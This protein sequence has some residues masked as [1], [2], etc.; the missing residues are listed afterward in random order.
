MLSK[1]KTEGLTT[2][3]R[4]SGI[5]SPQSVEAN[6]VLETTFE[7][8]EKEKTSDLLRPVCCFPVPDNTNE[9][10]ST[11]F[12]PQISV[13][14]D[15]P[16]PSLSIESHHKFNLDYK[17]DPHDKQY[18]G[19]SMERRKFD[20]L[21]IKKLLHENYICIYF[22]NFSNNAVSVELPNSGFS[23]QATRRI[24]SG[25]LLKA[26]EVVSLMATTAR[27]GGSSMSLRHE[28]AKSVDKTED[29]K[30]LPII[31]PLVRLPMWPS[32]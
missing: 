7:T 3:V 6:V 11:N 27:L 28:R 32:E 5:K 18:S 10:C 9:K 4:V 30:K 25:S 29:V 1:Y 14:V 19:N 8:I 15:P 20:Q 31:N 26:S 2:C 21:I 17:L 22:N 12:P 23:P 24:S 16:S 13:I